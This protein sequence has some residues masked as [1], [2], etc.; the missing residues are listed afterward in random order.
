VFEKNEKKIKKK[1]KVIIICLLF[2]GKVLYR[3]QTR[4]LFLYQIIIEKMDNIQKD[5][6]HPLRTCTNCPQTIPKNNTTSQYCVKCRPKCE[7]CKTK[8]CIDEL[9]VNRLCIKHYNE[10]METITEPIKAICTQC[11][12]PILQ[13]F[14]DSTP[15]CSWCFY[16]HFH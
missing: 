10:K 2:K 4:D 12:V 14:H 6:P 3:K 16:Y 7:E 1:I 5:I 8:P 9:S 11:R 13:S 15:L